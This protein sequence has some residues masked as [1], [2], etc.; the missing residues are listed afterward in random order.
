MPRARATGLASA[1]VPPREG[2]AS[3]QACP[4]AS[5][6]GESATP[7][8]RSLLLSSPECAGRC[9]DL[10]SA[11][12]GRNPHRVGNQLHPCFSSQPRYRSARNAAVGTRTNSRLIVRSAAHVGREIRSTGSSLD[13]GAMIAIGSACLIELL[14]EVAIKYFV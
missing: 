5:G 10:G 9:G 12:G 2:R 1:W 8:A 14:N 4:A 6:S 11:G 3:A 13:Y 7:P